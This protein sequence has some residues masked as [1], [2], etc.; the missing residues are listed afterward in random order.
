MNGDLC[1]GGL[2]QGEIGVHVVE[3]TDGLLPGADR[4]LVKPLHQRLEKSFAGIHLS[5]K[6]SAMVD[7]QDAIEVTFEGNGQ[8]TV[9]RFSRVPVSVVTVASK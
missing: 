1:A 3:M 7:R 2:F 5:T 9:E 4:D 6:V 8:K